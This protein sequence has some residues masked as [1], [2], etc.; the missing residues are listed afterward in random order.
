[1]LKLPLYCKIIAQRVA[2]SVVRNFDSTKSGVDAHVLKL[3][4]IPK[5]VDVI[6][7][8]VGQTVIKYYRLNTSRTFE[9]TGRSIFS[10]KIK[11]QIR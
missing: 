1:M 3:V 5:T 2:Q 11:D 4:I 8:V 7:Y 10:V 9:D 6:P